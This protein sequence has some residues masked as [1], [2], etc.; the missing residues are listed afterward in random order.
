MVRCVGARRA[1]EVTVLHWPRWISEHALRWQE[2]ALGLA[3]AAA[4]FAAL[5]MLRGVVRR[6]HAAFAAT[7]ERETL[8]LPALAFSRTTMPFMVVIAAFAGL[9]PFALPPRIEQVAGS[10]AMIALFWQAGLWASTAAS[11]WLDGRAVDAARSGKTSPGSVG[12]LRFGVRAV[13]WA[14]VVLLT[15]ENVGVDITALVAGLGIGGVAVALA[16]Q[17][18]LG[19]L[20]ASL[21]ITLD[22]PFVV[23]DFIVTGDNMGTVEYIGIKSTRLRSLTGEQIVM[24]NSDL[25]SSPVRNFKRMQER[26]VVVTLGVEYETPRAR[27]E[28]IVPVVRRTIEECEGVRFDRCH[29]AGFGADSLRFEAVYYVLS[30]DFN[31]H[32]D[33]QQ[34]IFFAIHAEFARLGVAFAYPTRKVWLAEPPGP[35]G[36]GV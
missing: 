10:V 23:G 12:I 21:S 34:K 5:W 25:L 20:L 30:A 35:T 13:I 29:F 26:R 18:V 9:Q 3:I 32:M 7:P 19:D 33:L 16:L 6:R 11:A 8:E 31:R 22:E 27:L 24:P 28:E 14:M 15:L 1:T 36:T 17:N 2:V 4:V